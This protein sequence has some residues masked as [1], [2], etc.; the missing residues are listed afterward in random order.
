[1][2]WA[3][4]VGVVV[5]LGSVA[6]AGDLDER[7]AEHALVTDVAVRAMTL[8]GAAVGGAVTIYAPGITKHSNIKLSRAVDHNRMDDAWSD[9]ATRGDPRTLTLELGA[10]ETV[11][12]QGAIITAQ[13]RELGGVE[14]IEICYEKLERVAR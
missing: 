10:R 14:K 7:F 13:T 2:A 11:I 6:C 12:A 8:D 9:W 1:M 5:V 3:K 4:I